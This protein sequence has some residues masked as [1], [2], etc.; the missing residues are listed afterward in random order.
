MKILYSRK[1]SNKDEDT[2][3]VGNKVET[4]FHGLMT[5][6]FGRHG[7]HSSQSTQRIIKEIKKFNPD[8]IHL[9]N[10]HGYWVNVPMLLRI[11]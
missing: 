9:H 8:I 7:L 10:L 1:S 6:I 4:A 5:K 11:P 2:V 3:F